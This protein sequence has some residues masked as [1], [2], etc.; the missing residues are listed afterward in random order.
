MLL[1]VIIAVMLGATIAVILLPLL[2]GEDSIATRAVYD[3]N[4]FKDQLKAIDRDLTEG[5][6]DESDAEAARV[7]ISRKL[8]EA[9][10]KAQEKPVIKGGEPLG[11]P[12]LAGIGG[13]MIVVALG[14]YGLQGS[15][16]LPDQ[17]LQARLQQ[18]PENQRIDEL[19]ARAE[20]QLQKNPSDGRGWAIMAPIYLR[21]SMYDKAVVAFRNAIRL[22]GPDGAR[23]TGL[24]DALVFANQ[25]VVSD[26][27]V[28]V[29]KQA[30]KA[31]PDQP[32]PHFWL[33]LYHEQQGK[34][35]QASE[36][37][38]ALLKR[39]SADAPWRQMVQDRFNEVRKRQ[40]LPPLTIAGAA[41][42][43]PPVLAPPASAPAAAPS[44]AT[45]APGP[46][47]ED[48]KQAGELSPEDR[49]AMINNMVANLAERLQEEGGDLQSWMRLLNAYNVL[50]KKE[51][52]RQALT[53]ARKNLAKDKKALTQ[54]DALARKIGLESS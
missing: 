33:A 1:W 14:L 34:L 4:V 44:G 20:R 17:P 30:I 21:H 49:Q 52:A 42:A 45:A 18:K 28:P 38:T 24:S 48:I 10:D 12:V 11:L 2:R 6:I 40:G 35:K 9:S 13:A 31:D 19:I 26:E 41:P 22:L 51:E 39:A 53:Q 47:A 36:G 16:S 29:L 27:T 15:P 23:L 37:Y 3:A 43:A 32:K 7:E 25:G 5:L 50:G 54:L 8:L 46:T